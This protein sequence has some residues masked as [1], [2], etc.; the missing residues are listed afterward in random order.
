ME[1]K[2]ATRK[3]FDGTLYWPSTLTP[4]DGLDAHPSL[5]EKVVTRVAIIGGGMTGAILAASLTRA[6]IPSVILESGR[7]ASAS[8][9]ASTGL[10]QFS[11][12]IMLC[13][14]AE[15]IGEAQAVGFYEQCRQS[16]A[17]LGLLAE[18]AG[19]KGAALQPA[20]S[21]Y[22]ASSD[23]DEKRLLCE[24]KLL[25]RNGFPV[26]WGMPKSVP[27]SLSAYKPVAMTAYGDA[28]A[29]PPLLA[30]TLLRA[31]VAGGCSL[32]ENSP[33]REVKRRGGK[34]TILAGEG[35]VTASHVVVATG[36]VPGVAAAAQLKPILRR[37]YALATQPGSVPADFPADTMLWETA[38]PYFYFRTT[39]DGRI[40]AGGLDE[41]RPDPT[42]DE[43]F[44]AD[45]SAM[46]IADLSR[47]FPNAEFRADYAWCGMFGESA[48]DLP[49]IGEDREQPGLFHALGCGGNGTV[50]STLAARMLLASI[51]GEKHP[52]ASLLDPR[53]DAASSGSPSSAPATRTRL[54]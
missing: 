27:A 3:L 22:A 37:T 31:A 13:E 20:T 14:L 23:E 33:V 42:G 16:V 29:N 8:T 50:Y 36:Y 40:V 43:T 48:D 53:R 7:A 11:N 45:R 26:S 5:R 51:A 24:Y 25:E 19:S 4:S 54:A 52:L 6:G 49:F 30:R 46:L 32:Y 38:R 17:M 10:L 9:A 2:T 28:L 15:R 34:W 18:A 47:Y 12:D 21:L 1:K 41:D 39:P 44:L 35:E